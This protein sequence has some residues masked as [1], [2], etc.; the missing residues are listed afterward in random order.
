MLVTEL[1]KPEN[2]LTLSLGYSHPVEMID[3][4]ELRLFWKDRTRSLFRELTK[5]KLASMR[6]R[7]E[8]REDR[9]HIRAK[10]SSMLMK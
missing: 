5:K 2:K 9:S 4:R 8:T 6:L 3:Q 10:V 1:Q 7:S